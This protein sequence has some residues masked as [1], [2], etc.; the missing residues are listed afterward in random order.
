MRQKSPKIPSHPILQN[1]ALLTTFRIHC[2][3]LTRPGW[4]M[5]DGLIVRW[6]QW[7][8][9]GWNQRPFVKV[10]GEGEQKLFCPFLVGVVKKMILSTWTT[11]CVLIV[12]R[13]L[14]RMNI[15]LTH[16]RLLSKQPVDHK[17]PKH[18][19]HIK[20]GCCETLCFFRSFLSCSLDLCIHF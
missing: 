10:Q 11:K 3:V 18:I 1:W 13:C 15:K 5:A 6:P 16:I 2:Q 19:P 8:P 7:F 20:W 14:L 4:L 12:A 17:G 9:P